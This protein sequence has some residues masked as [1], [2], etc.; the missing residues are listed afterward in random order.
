MEMPLGTASRTHVSG[1]HPSDPNA[2]LELKT[3]ADLEAMCLSEVGRR[4]TQA[5]TTPFLTSPLI[6]IFTESNLSTRA[7]DQVLAGKFV[8]PEAVNDLTK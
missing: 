7:F 2:G 8:C 5:T 4:F 6:D 1:P 3:K